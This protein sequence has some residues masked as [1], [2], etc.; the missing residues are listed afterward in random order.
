MQAIGKIVTKFEE[1]GVV[2][3]IERPMHY[4]CARFASNITIV[5][6]NLAEDTHVSFPRPYQELGLSY[7]SLWHIL[8]LDLHLHPYKVQFTQQLKS[9]DHSQHRKH[10]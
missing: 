1:T 3:N 7:G 6:E 5:S 2:T 9:A 10:S 8:H 4:H